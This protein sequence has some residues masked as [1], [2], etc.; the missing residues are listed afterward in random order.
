M[1]KGAWQEKRAGG[2]KWGPMVCCWAGMATAY[3][4]ECAKE[5]IGS[6]P[7]CLVNKLKWQNEEG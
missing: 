6:G 3:V 5:K 7:A 1:V 4:T 2:R